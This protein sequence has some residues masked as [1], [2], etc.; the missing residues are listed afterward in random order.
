MI[1]LLCYVPNLEAIATLERM[2]LLCLYLFLLKGSFLFCFWVLSSYFG[3]AIRSHLC[4]Y[5]ILQLVISG[6]L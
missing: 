6:Q 4:G 3:R 5:V 2:Y 1:L